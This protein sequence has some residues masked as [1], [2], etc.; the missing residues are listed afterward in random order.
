[1][2]ASPLGRYSDVVAAIVALAL[3]FGAM[4]QHLLP[5]F[6]GDTAWIDNGALLAIG[7]VLGQRATTNGAAKI[8][9]AAHLRLDAIHAP[10][11]EAAAVD[12]AADAGAKGPV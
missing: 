6:T 10:P 12:V 7:V 11:A 4:L 2:T 5:G 3:I 8:A 1:M 9:A